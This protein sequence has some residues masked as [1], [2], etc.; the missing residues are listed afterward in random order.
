MAK[1]GTYPNHRNCGLCGKSVQQHTDFLHARLRGAAVLF[2]W[3]CFLRQMRE[4][5]QQNPPYH[6]SRN[7]NQR[8][9]VLPTPRVDTGFTALMPMKAGR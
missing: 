1:F 9:P 5:L 3:C 6:P 2:H 8:P 4:S 7:L